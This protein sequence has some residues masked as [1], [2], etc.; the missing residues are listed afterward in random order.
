MDP[1]T[2]PVVSAG[3]RPNPAHAPAVPIILFDDGKNEY[4]G[5]PPRK[6]LAGAM[7]GFLRLV[8]ALLTGRQ[9][10]G[11]HRDNT[12]FKTTN[13]HLE[14][15]RTD[16]QYPARAVARNTCVALP[17]TGAGDLGY[18]FQISILGSNKTY[19][20]WVQAASGYNSANRCQCRLR[21]PAKAGL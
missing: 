15:R 5:C 10:V 17:R 3:L 2:P 12:L 9:A 4:S 14:W 19:T 1:R 21:K 11:K 20:E 13:C 6:P 8:G 18:K 7:E 16:G